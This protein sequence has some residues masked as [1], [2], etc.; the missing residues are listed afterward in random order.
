MEWEIMKQLEHPCL[1]YVTAIILCLPA[2]C[3]KSSTP[4]EPGNTTE[5]SP[6]VVNSAAP[7]TVTQQTDAATAVSERP[8]RQNERW[9]D[10]NGV[11]YLGD[12]PLDVFFDEPLKIARNQTPLGGGMTD[13]AANGGTPVLPSGSSPTFDTSMSNSPAETGD[14]SADAFSW[15]TLLSIDVLQNEVTDAR[16][17]LN[18]SVQSYGDYK[19]VTLMIPGKAA[20]LAVLASVAM[21]H[22]QEVNWKS[23]AI[24]IRDLARQMNDDPLQANKKDHTK[25][26]D[27]FENIASTLDRSRPAGLEEP[28]P[29]DSFVDVA[30]MDMVMVRLDEA[31]K[32]LKT[33][34]GSQTAFESKKE[35]INHEAAILATFSHVVTL[36]GYGYADDEEFTGYANQIVKAAQRIQ[37]ATESNDFNSY[38]LALSKVSTSCSECHSAYRNN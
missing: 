9:T 8:R 2:G 29:E 5:A 17:F 22:P 13:V 20:S 12:V 35:M 32:K 27:L 26:L 19:K 33:E 36:E 28:N 16:N 10:E 21:E 24:Y 30:G 3:G 7:G 38:E 34:A 18:R 14:A 4:A 37:N 6:A 1:L 15:D 23:D 25:V 31:E 11:D